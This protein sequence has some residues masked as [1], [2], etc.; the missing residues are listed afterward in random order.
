MWL[1]VGCTDQEKIPSINMYNY[2]GE[3]GRGGYNM[4]KEQLRT[5]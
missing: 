2:N 5:Y 3:A 1:W 4:T